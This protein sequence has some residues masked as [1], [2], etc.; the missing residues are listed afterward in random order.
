MVRILQVDLWNRQPVWIALTKIYGIGL[1]RGKYLCSKLGI[2]LKTKA[3][4]L[5]QYQAAGL[6]QLIEDERWVIKQA[7][8]E[9][10][11]SNIRRLIEIK[12]RR[13][14]MHTRHLPVNGQRTKSNAQTAKKRVPKF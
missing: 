7:L 4:E 5:H 12:C 11:K 13:G 10:T 2:S 14:V 1:T 9:Q 6:A 8:K 3:G